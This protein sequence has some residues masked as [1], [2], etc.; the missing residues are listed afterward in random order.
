MHRIASVF[1]GI[2]KK[3]Q[4]LSQSPRTTQKRRRTISSSDNGSR[5]T[6]FLATTDYPVATVDNTS[7]PQATSLNEAFLSGT[8]LQEYPWDIGFAPNSAVFDSNTSQAENVRAGQGM[9]FYDDYLGNMP[10]YNNNALAGF[11][12]MMWDKSQMWPMNFR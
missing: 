11:D 5:K 4:S 3:V 2:A 12:W 6:A 1:L 8:D 7:S 9:T 10:V